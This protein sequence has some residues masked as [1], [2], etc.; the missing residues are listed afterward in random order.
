MK[1]LNT[2][3]K[4]IDCRIIGNPD[5]NIK[6]ISV[7]SQKTEA[8]DLFVVIDGYRT[9]GRLYVESAIKNGASAIATKDISL[10]KIIIKK[11]SKLTA[12][13]VPNPRHF[14][15][16]VTNSFYDYPSK[17]LSLIGITG[18]DGK[19]T[20]SFMIKSILEAAGKKTGLLGTIKY[21]DGLKWYSAPNT[22]PESLDFVSFLAD[23]VKRKIKYCISEVS[24]HALV[25]DRT[26]GLDFKAGVFTNLTQDHLD[27]HKTIRAYSEAKLKLFK[28]LSSLSFAVINYD[29]KFADK[30]IKNTKAKII[31]YCLN[32]KCTI[33]A[34]IKKQTHK[35]T[36][37]VIFFNK[38]SQ[39]VKIK[40][41]MI[42]IHNVYNMMAAIGVAKALGI[43]NQFIKLGLEKLTV[44]PGR[45][46]RIK[47][48]KDFNIYIDYAHTAKALNVAITTLKHITRGN[49]IVVFGC[50]GNRDRQKR[51]VMG[52]VATEL[53]DYAV[54]T[55][56]NPRFEKP[57][58]ITNE[59]RKGIKGKNFEIIIDRA[60]AIKRAI[61]IAKPDDT[62]LIA[63]KGHED[64]QIIGN[65]PIRFSDKQIAFRELRKM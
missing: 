35:G 59:I 15:A 34:K 60:H 24:S 38:K 12:V 5:V 50:G 1:K 17:K 48:N 42:G 40:L 49:M 53:C 25:L 29:D 36:D 22:T 32:K 26:A 11:H 41:P 64:Y 14:L 63:G 19:T 46:E 4:K 2:L 57:E 55:S 45:L 58:A 18:T 28:N 7:H 61:S 47:T 27:F 6:G 51:P 44:V 65:K 23:L 8:G 30:I 33:F 62:V 31:T 56:D 13:Y 43:S 21:Y 10:A 52:K 16:E 37:I 54:I 20:T 3:C 39:Q 9:S